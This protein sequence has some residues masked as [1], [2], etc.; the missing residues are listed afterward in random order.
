MVYLALMSLIYANAAICEK[1]ITLLTKLLINRDI[2]IMSKKFCEIQVIAYVVPITIS[3]FMI[4]RI[5]FI[6]LFYISYVN[7]SNYFRKEYL[8]R[9]KQEEE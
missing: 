7:Y 9:R 3:N 1:L 5:Y 6:L 2:K 4:M 8:Q